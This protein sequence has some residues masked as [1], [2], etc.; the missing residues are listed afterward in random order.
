MPPDGVM[1]TE[2]L[3]RA[4]C[5]VHDVRSECSLHLGRGANS[6]LRL[7]LRSFEQFLDRFLEVLHNKINRLSS[8]STFLICL[9]FHIIEIDNVTPTVHQLNFYTNYRNFLY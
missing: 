3:L 1:G 4:G 6:F 7:F 9:I 2:S 8:A 5:G